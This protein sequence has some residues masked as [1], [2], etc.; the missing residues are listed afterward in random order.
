MKTLLPLLVLLLA[1]G[2]T[3]IDMTGYEK[4]KPELDM[5]EYF[6]EPAKGWGIVQNR[7]GSLLRYFTVDIESELTEAGQLVLHESFVWNDG[8]RSTRTWVLSRENKHTYSG[9]AGDVV[10][11]AGGVAYGNVLNWRYVLNVKVDKTIWKIAFDDWMFQVDDGILINRARMS[12][13]GF[14]V[15]EVTLFFSKQKS[16]G[17]ARQ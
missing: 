14:T 3:G 9:T 12:K 10:G 5:F 13:F 6:K 11:K 8:E 17:G 16:K 1:A 15:G 2:C 4:N 7:K